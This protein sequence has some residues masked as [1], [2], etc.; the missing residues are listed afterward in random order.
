MGNAYVVYSPA[1]GKSVVSC[2][3]GI[4]QITKALREKYQVYTD[5][6]HNRLVE[7]ACKKDFQI[8]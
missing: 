4:M 2:D 1:M 5:I 6:Q 7:R 8:H 3:G